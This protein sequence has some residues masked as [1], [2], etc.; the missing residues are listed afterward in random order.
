[1]IFSRSYK[2]KGRL[3]FFFIFLCR[4]VLD[5]TASKMKA[6]VCVCFF[7]SQKHKLNPNS[8]IQTNGLQSLDGISTIVA[9]ICVAQACVRNCGDRE[10]STEFQWKENLFWSQWKLKMV[11]IIFFC[12]SP[13]ATVTGISRIPLFFVR[14]FVCPFI[15]NFSI[16]Y[17][18][19][20][21]SFFVSAFVFC[22]SITE[23]HSLFSTKPI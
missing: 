1:M 8:R 2:M 12:H 6:T 20:P 19:F 10:S 22:N 14:T 9:T 11:A 16:Y 21:S 13:A 15:S 5:K 17:F 3:M 7:L 4:Y 18:H 23:S